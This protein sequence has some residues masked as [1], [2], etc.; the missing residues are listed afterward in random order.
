MPRHVRRDA[1]AAPH[2]VICRGIERLPIVRDETDRA[3]FV[4]R[5]GQV[6]ATTGTP[7]CAWALLPTHSHSLLRTGAVPLTT[8][9]RRV[10]TGYEGT[11][12]RC[13]RSL[14]ERR[15][16]NRQPVRA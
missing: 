7:C 8:I 3:A 4:E 13:C 15:F 2:H 1:S 5:L 12:N 6:L 9:M 14:Q 11:F 16:L 10:L